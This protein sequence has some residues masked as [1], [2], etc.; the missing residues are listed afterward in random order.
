MKERIDVD[1]DELGKVKKRLEQQA[2][3]IDRIINSLNAQIDNLRNG[4]WIG[5]GADAF[6]AEM[7]NAVL[8]STTR[9]SAALQEAGETTNRA[10][11]DFK[12]AEDE[13]KACF[14]I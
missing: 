5:L 14:I 4:G 6:Y 11:V 12:K 10:M 9:L 2:D 7:D 1:Y 8:P 13:A 3:A